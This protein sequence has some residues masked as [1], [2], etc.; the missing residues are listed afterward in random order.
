MIHKVANGVTCV[1]KYWFAVEFQGQ[2]VLRPANISLGKGFRKSADEFEKLAHKKTAIRAQ[3][4][5]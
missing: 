2:S 4:K 5:V 1:F 3:K